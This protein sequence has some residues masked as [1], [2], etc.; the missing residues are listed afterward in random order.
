MFSPEISESDI[1]NVVSALRK[2][3][4]SGNF[5]SY[6]DEFEKKYAEFCGTK[7]AIAVSSG[8]TALHLAISVL[9]LEPGSEVL[10]STSTNIATA[11]AVVHNNLVPVPVDSEFETWNLDLLDLEKKI[12]KKTRAI[13]PVHLF[14]HPVQMEK[15]MAIAEKYSLKVVEDCAESHGATVNGKMTGSFGDMGCFSFYANKILTTG[16]GG[17]VVTN[18]QDLNQKL[19]L[20]RNLAFSTPRFMHEFNA[21]NF[22]M[23][24]YQA[25]LGL[26]Q[27]SRIDTIL[28]KKLFVAESY[29][30]EFCDNGALTFQSQA[31][32]AK[33]V[34]WMFGILL[35]GNSKITR[36]D[37]MA[38]LQSEGIETR[39]FFCPMDLQPSL[40]TKFEMFECPNARYMWD[41]GLYL[42][43]STNL[44]SLEIGHISQLVNKLTGAR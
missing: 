6:L 15:L 2:G 29:I 23:T 22:R 41:N 36:D 16:E 20:F 5:G 39:T 34:Y 21:Y 11:L 42:P 7:Y 18:N 14:G 30:K 40:A 33:N 12:T 3:E 38:T 35:N 28:E 43:S 37:L 13:I 9:D 27:L 24:G 4:I 31:S 10:I 32:W 19:R 8:T 1:A 25:A 17:M 44:T 26:S